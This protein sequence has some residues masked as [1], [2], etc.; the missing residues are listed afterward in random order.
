MDQMMAQFQAG[1]QRMFQR[2]ADTGVQY[3]HGAGGPA[4]GQHLVA[5][6]TAPVTTAVPPQP[7]L[8]QAPQQGGG[9]GERRLKNGM[10]RSAA[11]D[12]IERASGKRPGAPPANP[13]AKPHGI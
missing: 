9:G 7:A 1:Q 4:A 11:L 2:V 10:S 6:G 8:Q 12:A 13:N 3:K 5:Q